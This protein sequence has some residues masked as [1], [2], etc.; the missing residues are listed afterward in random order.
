MS[1]PTSAMPQRPLTLTEELE[2]LEQSIT[3]TLQ[4]IDHNFS[5]AHRIVTSSILPLVEQYAEHSRDVWDGA[6]FWKQ[7]FEAS[8]NVSL[9]GYEERPNEEGEGDTSQ[10]HTVTEDDPSHITHSQLSESASYETPSSAR[11][12]INHR[13]DDLELTSLS[14]SSHST[15]RAP[16]HMNPNTADDTISSIAH[17]SPY[18][19]G[20]RAES[21]AYDDDDLPTT[22]GRHSRPR[23]YSHENTSRTPMSSSPFIP[24]VSRDAPP[25]TAGTR[26]RAGS[27]SDPVL[28]RV[29]DKTYRVQATPLGKGHAAGR[30]KFTVTP[31]QSSSKYAADDSPLSSPEMEA[32]RLHAEIFSSPLKTPGTNRKRRTSSHLRATPKPGTSVL[33]PAKGSSRPVWDSDDDFEDEDETFGPSPPK[34]MQFHIPQS[35]LMKTPAKEASK[36]IVEH[37][38]YTAGANDTTDDIQDEQ[39]PSMVRRMER[40]EDDTF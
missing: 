16:P 28:H 37:L 40:L 31:K 8:A 34:T 4:E 23:G 25:S 2:K 39:S 7:F 38:L 36:R 11:L 30:S 26:H 5:Q 3:L 14:L 24:P 6:K 12:D 15:P 35:R 17:P 13:A 21:P 1:R 27:G 10:E 33:T 19:H 32:P 22:P 18:D 9:S 20:Q 29:L